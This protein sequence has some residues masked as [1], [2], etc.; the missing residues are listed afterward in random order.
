MPDP[1]TRR[2][3]LRQTATGAAAP[4]ILSSGVLAADGR[5]G[6]NDKINVALIGAGGQGN[7]NLDQLLKEPGCVVVG[8]CDVWKERLDAALAK[9]KGTAKGYHDYRE[10]LAQKDIDAVLIATPPHWH[11]LMAIDAC[12]AGIDFYLE[13][14]MTLYPGE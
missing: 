2:R 8:V 5:K 4:Y 14:P 11:A 13:K 12:E 1:I 6:P 9:C 10:V 3:F 7:W